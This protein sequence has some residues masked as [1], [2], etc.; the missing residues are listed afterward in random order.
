M[1]Q[2]IGLEMVLKDASAIAS[3][4]PTVVWQP[5]KTCQ[6]HPTCRACL[7]RSAGASALIVPGFDRDHDGM[8]CKRPCSW[9]RECTTRLG[10]FSLR[11][12]EKL[13]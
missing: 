3:V 11:Y 6:S 13:A 5:L 12:P 7:A 1:E 2:L 9:A 4:G 10:V 8:D